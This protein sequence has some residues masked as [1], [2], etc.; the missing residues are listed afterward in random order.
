MKNTLL[1]MLRQGNGEQ[2]TNNNTNEMSYNDEQKSSHQ[3]HDK[4][5][6]VNYDFLDSDVFTNEGNNVRLAEPHTFEDA[7]VIV[8]AIKA[9]KTVLMFL[10][11]VAKDGVDSRILDFVSG[12][13]HAFSIQPQKTR[14]ENLWVIDPQHKRTKTSFR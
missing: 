7:E 4:Y 3:L 12:Y 2:E 8:E 10:D 14:N 9:G 1:A 5:P 6:S 13:C 11:N